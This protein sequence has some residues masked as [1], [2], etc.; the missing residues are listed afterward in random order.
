MNNEL[1]VISYLHLVLPNTILQA[2]TFF[3]S[4]L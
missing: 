2:K 1:E 4:D 3:H